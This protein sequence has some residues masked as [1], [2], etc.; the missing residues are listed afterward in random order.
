MDQ[1]P[2]K[3]IIEKMA[4]MVSESPIKKDDKKVYL[5]RLSKI[6]FKLL[7]YAYQS[8]KKTLTC[9]DMKYIICFTADINVK[10]ICLLFNIEPASVHTVRYRIKK[11]FSKNDTFRIVF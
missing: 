11:K 8:S 1:W 6:D 2:I 3:N 9:L 10:D 4:Q 5:A 7:E